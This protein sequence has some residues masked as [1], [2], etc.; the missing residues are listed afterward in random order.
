VGHFIYCFLAAV[1]DRLTFQDGSW[2]HY[3]GTEARKLMIN[4]SS[5]KNKTTIKFPQNL[6]I[7]QFQKI[8]KR[9]VKLIPGKLFKKCFGVRE[10]KLPPNFFST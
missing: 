3:I 9:S 6:Y 5:N 1:S 2:G 10:I 7:K 4:L 8:Y